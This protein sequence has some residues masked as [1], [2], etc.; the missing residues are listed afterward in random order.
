MVK[1]GHA[2]SFQKRKIRELKKRP[3]A[4]LAAL[5]E[6]QA[7]KVP[8]KLRGLDIFVRRRPV[9]NGAL[10]VTVCVELGPMSSTDG[11]EITPRGRITPLNDTPAYPKP[12]KPPVHARDFKPEVLHYL[13]LEYGESPRDPRALK[14]SELR[15]EGKHLGEGVLTHFWSYPT[16]SGRRY[17]TVALRG[18]GSTIDMSDHGPPRPPRRRANGR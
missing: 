12:R 18:A 10:E 11:F 14:S 6:S 4:R 7:L 8:R 5:P 13:H 17:A 3:F 2:S 9:R 16:S 15:Y 1:L